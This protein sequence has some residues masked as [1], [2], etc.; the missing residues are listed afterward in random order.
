VH[1]GRVVVLQR[2]ERRS[3]RSLHVSR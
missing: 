3:R 2:M 1:A